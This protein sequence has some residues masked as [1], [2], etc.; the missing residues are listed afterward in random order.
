LAVP[1]QTSS[2]AG[3][4]WLST[5]VFSGHWL[6]LHSIHG[7]VFTGI[8]FQIVNDNRL[9]VALPAGLST[10]AT[11]P[12]CNLRHDLR[13]RFLDA[14]VRNTEASNTCTRK[15]AADLAIGMALSIGRAN[16]QQ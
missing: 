12:V 16:L 3:G 8:G 11:I 2:F 14:W 13:R 5:L 7:D 10:Y 9:N 4:Y 6:V 1:N 15:P